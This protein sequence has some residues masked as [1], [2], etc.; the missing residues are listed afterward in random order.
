MIVASRYAK[1]LID[2]AQETGQ[3]EE[4]RKD[5][6]L[7]NEVSKN[8]RDFIVLLQSPVVKTD[9]K[10]AI[11][12]QLFEGKVSKT[13][14]A[15]LN[16]LASKRRESYIADVASAFDEQYKT[17]K[18]IITVKV[19]SAVP[20]DEKTKAEILAPVKSAHKGAIALVEKVNPSLIGGFVLTINDTQID[21][22][23]RR[24][25]NDLRKGFADNTH[26]T[27]LN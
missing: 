25:L 26:I 12:K 3:L 16:L 18:N 5:M 24:K 17:L 9:K 19:E 6:Q 22:S 2:L 14:F 21:H 23:V 8:N 20:L 15:F 27:T 7:I 11:F 13:T 1:S 4:V 10:Q